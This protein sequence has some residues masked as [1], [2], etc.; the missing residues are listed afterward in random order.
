MTNLKKIIKKILHESSIE[1]LNEVKSS[2]DEVYLLTTITGGVMMVPKS[3]NPEITAVVN[4]SKFKQALSTTEQIN[5]YASRARF[6]TE[7][8]NKFYKKMPLDECY[9]FYVQTMFNRWVDGGIAR[10]TATLPG[11][12]DRKN[13]SACWVRGKNGEP[14][15]FEDIK[16]S[17]YYPNIN[18]T[19]GC[20]GNPW[21]IKVS[22]TEEE[23]DKELAPTIKFQIKLPMIK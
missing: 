11:T 22:D 21:K 10:F 4:K 20:E 9:A 2:Q 15:K 8:C 3:S 14:I 1:K 17:G 12:N 13:F 16:F 18:E 23:I 7:A 6:V 5:S 19:G